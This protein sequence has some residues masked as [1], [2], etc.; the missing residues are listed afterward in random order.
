M[1][2]VNVC[3]FITF[4]LITIV[5]IGCLS[6]GAMGEAE[7]LVEVKDY[8]GA[9]EVYQSII[10]TKSGAV[11]ARAAQLAIGE[12]YIAHLNQPERGIKTYQAVIAE[13]PGSSEAAEARYR[14]GRQ[15]YH[16]KDYDAAQTYFRTI[17]IRFSH[18]RLHHNAQLMLAKSYE[19]G[20]KY[21]QAAE[22]FENFANEYP[23]SERAA[24]ALT[25]KARIQREHLKNERAE[26]HVEKPITD[27]SGHNTSPF[28][29][30]PYLEVPADFPSQERLW[31]N[32]TPEHE[33]LVRVRIKLW[34]QGTQTTGA[35]FGYNG[36]IYPTVPNVIYVDWTY[37]GEGPPEFLGIRYVEGILGDDKASKKWRASNRPRDRDQHIDINNDRDVSGIKVYEYPDGGIDPYKFLGL[38]KSLAQKP[39][40]QDFPEDVAESPLEKAK[41]ELEESLK[42]YTATAAKTHRGKGK[43][44][45]NDIKY[46]PDG[47]R[48]AVAGNFGTFLYDVLT[49][50]EPIKFTSHRGRVM[51]IAF[52]PDGTLLANVNATG[53]I[54]LWDVNTGQHL[55]TIFGSGGWGI[56]FSPDGGT[57]ATGS[58]Y[59][60]NAVHLL[61]THTGELLRT[62]TGHTDSVM[63]VAFSPDG[64]TIATGGS[65]RDGTVRL[66]DADMGKPLRTLKGHVYKVWSVAF[67]PDGTLLASSGYDNTI[68]LWDVNTGQRVRILGESEPGWALKPSGTIGLP[69][70]VAFSPDGKTIAGSDFLSIRLWNVNTGKLFRKFRERSGGHGS[71]GMVFSPDGWTLAVFGSNEVDLWDAESGQLVRTLITE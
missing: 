55:R 46:S 33:L 27:S 61:D 42:R 2:F 66:W 68:R 16:Q 6:T 10:D 30:G 51:R 22:T 45:I 49:D 25:N 37:I 14:L 54:S 59:G 71:G 13:A 23:Q 32:A 64:E 8:S 41:R 48:L 29:F 35:E 28:G 7:K 18:L 11:E 3:L 17:V 1:K 47:T 63:T 24:Q 53:G 62:L 5:Q 70:C 4:V 40:P 39:P 34:K 52:S 50:D 60:D 31:E 56:A 65:H 58:Y 26:S 44:K 67:S 43:I 19:A 20:Q 57:I 15:A 38:P 9:I 21:E 12:L 69:T 36:R